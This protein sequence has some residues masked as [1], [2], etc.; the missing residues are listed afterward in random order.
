MKPLQSGLAY[1]RGLLGGKHHEPIIFHFRLTKATVEPTSNQSF[2]LQL[3][4]SGT[5]HCVAC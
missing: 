2:S 5:K 4:S 3:N 1:R